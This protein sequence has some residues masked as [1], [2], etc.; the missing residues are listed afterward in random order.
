MRS[1]GATFRSPVPRAYVILGDSI[2]HR[3]GNSTAIAFAPRLPIALGGCAGKRLHWQRTMRGCYPNPAAISSNSITRF[4]SRH[5]VWITI[6]A[7]ATDVVVRNVPDGFVGS[8]NEL[9]DQARRDVRSDVMRSASIWITSN[10]RLW[11]DRVIDPRLAACGS[12][13]GPA[14]DHRKAFHQRR[15]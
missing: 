15:P 13:R 8:E 9:F 5:F 12:A 7:K 3:P 14:R 11:T 4:G 6:T 1:F 2:V 10:F